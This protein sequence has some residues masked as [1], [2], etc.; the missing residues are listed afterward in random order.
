M[1]KYIENKDGSIRKWNKKDSLLALLGG[2]YLVL[3]LT[4]AL[5]FP[6]I[7]YYIENR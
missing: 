2:I 5:W 3:V 4:A 6:I 1:T 7:S